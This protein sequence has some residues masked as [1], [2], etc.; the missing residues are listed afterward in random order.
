MAV[1]FAAVPVPV[2]HQ[3]LFRLALLDVV[4]V[5]DRELFLLHLLVEELADLE[6]DQPDR[7]RNRRH[8]GGSHWNDSCK[9][10]EQ[11]VPLL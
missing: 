1:G 3:L 11:N 8:G 6:D 4:A 9:E 5:L 10:K 2:D 7:E